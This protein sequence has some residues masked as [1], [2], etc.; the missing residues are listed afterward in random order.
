MRRAMLAAATS[1]V[2]LLSGVSATA[3]AS[4]QPAAPPSPTSTALLSTAETGC[5][6]IAYWRGGLASAVRP[7]VPPRYELAP[8]PAP[9]GFP[10]RVA[11]VINELTCRTTVNT[12]PGRRDEQRDVTT[13]IISVN[14]TSIDGQPSDGYYNLL[15]ATENR[16]QQRTLNRLGWQA[17]LLKRRSGIDVSTSPGGLTQAALSVRGSGWGHDVSGATIFPL[18]QAT[19]GQVAFRR[20]TPQGQLQ[21]CVDTLEAS[22]PGAVT[23][24]LTGTPFAT[25]TA[26]PP[27]YAGFSGTAPFTTTL[28]KGDQQSTLTDETCPA[29]TTR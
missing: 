7:L 20:D 25:I 29:P 27:T 19:R 12:R 5:T 15:Y 8:F 2:L 17:D 16:T 6:E 1:G 18:N 10:A 3:H 26:A 4:P 14:T 23:G 21:L 24:D 11:L 9:D 28:I 22:A 13:I